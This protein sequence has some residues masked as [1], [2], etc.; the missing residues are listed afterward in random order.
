M[1]SVLCVSKKD[2]F[3]TSS[4]FRNSS[5]YVFKDLFTFFSPF[6][7][8]EKSNWSRDLSYAGVVRGGKIV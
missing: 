6:L 8:N 5:G 2:Q 4:R 7:V 1:S 3:S